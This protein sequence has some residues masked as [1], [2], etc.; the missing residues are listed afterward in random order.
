MDEKH[1]QC[2]SSSMSKIGVR[3][4]TALPHTSSGSTFYIVNTFFFNI[5]KQN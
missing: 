5:V 1:L 4:D 3:S 2:N